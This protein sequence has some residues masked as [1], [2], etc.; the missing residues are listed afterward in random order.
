MRFHATSATFSWRLLI[1]IPAFFCL[2]CSGGGKY[3]PTHG[4]VL[5]NN[6]PIEGVV[7]TFHPQRKEKLPDLPFGVTREDGTFEV[8]TGKS[9]GAPEGDYVVTFYCPQ[10]VEEKPVKKGKSV[11]MRMQTDQEDRFRGAFASEAK[12][13]HKV[14]IK[15][16]KNDLEPFNLN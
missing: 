5:Y 14:S 3:N 11:R 4:K 16:G 12:S 7:V 10:P 13:K 9:E 8:L 6:E 15:G 1:L 2:S